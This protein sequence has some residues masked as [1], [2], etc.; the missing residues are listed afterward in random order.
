[1]HEGLVLDSDINDVFFKCYQTCA[2][3]TLCCGVHIIEPQFLPGC[4]YN[5]SFYVKTFIF[6]KIESRD[7]LQSVI[8]TFIS[9]AHYCGVYIMNDYVYF[10]NSMFL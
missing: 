1:M 7:E 8:F 3:R 10:E 9:I 4:I 6:F 5:L 2:I